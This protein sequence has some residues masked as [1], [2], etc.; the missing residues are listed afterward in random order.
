MSKAFQ[1]NLGMHKA[2]QIINNT[3]TD[4]LLIYF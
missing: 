1:H 3:F 4:V 2:V